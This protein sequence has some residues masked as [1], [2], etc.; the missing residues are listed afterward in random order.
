MFYKD[1]ETHAMIVP[2]HDMH[3]KDYQRHLE[4]KKPLWGA[5]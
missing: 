4:E 3:D 2:K 1:S 5:K